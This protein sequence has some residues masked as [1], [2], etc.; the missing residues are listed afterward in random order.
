MLWIK[1]F[2]FFLVLT[3][4]SVSYGK[5]PI[6]GGIFQQW[7]EPI[8]E[9]VRIKTFKKEESQG[10]ETGGQVSTS[11]KT[12]TVLFYCRL[13]FSI[14]HQ[15]VQ[16][17]TTLSWQWRS[18]FSGLGIAFSSEKLIFH[19]TLNY[20]NY[21]IKKLNRTNDESRNNCEHNLFQFG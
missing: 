8:Q 18:L 1:Y 15:Q 14:F 13:A 3:Y 10:T 16:F 4:N 11:L 6:F 12:N 20:L 2:F 9:Q 5:P 21:G 7:V 19:T 17:Q